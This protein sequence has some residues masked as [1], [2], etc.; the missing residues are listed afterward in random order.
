MKNLNPY[1]LSL[2]LISVI[3]W[4]SLIVYFNRDTLFSEVDQVSEDLLH[5]NLEEAKNVEL[6]SS[7]DIE[8]V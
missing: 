4:S 3:C 7:E 8:D 1:G 5:M 2:C 6:S